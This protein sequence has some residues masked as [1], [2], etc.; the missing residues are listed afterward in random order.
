MEKWNV[1]IN[2]CEIFKICTEEF[3]FVEDQWKGRSVEINKNNW[4]LE[5]VDIV[6]RVEIVGVVSL[7]LKVNIIYVGMRKSVN[8]RS[9]R[10]WAWE[11]ENV[12]YVGLRK[13]VNWG[14]SRLWARE[15][16]KVS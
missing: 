1:N 11:E 8:W 4:N 5:R 12:S 7:S 13:S 10:V 2:I 15:E 16:E 3:H 9:S 14:C 6:E